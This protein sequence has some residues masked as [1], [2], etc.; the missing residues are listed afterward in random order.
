VL[1][2]LAIQYVLPLSALGFAYSQIGSTIRK[3]VKKNTTVD[4]Q[5]KQM[6]NKRNRKAMLLLLMLVLIYAVAWLPINL[7]NVLNVLDII[8][9]SQYRYIFCHLIGMCSACINPL[10][11]ALIN[12][13]FRTAFVSML[14]PFLRPCTKYVVVPG[15]QGAFGEGGSGLASNGREERYR[16]QARNPTHTTSSFNYNGESARVARGPAEP[17]TQLPLT[18]T[19]L[20]ARESN[21]TT[22][23]IDPPTDSGRDSRA[24]SERIELS[25]LPSPDGGNEQ[26]GKAAGNGHAV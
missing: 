16:S 7:Y 5:R 14:S 18:L 21:I 10:L 26:L 13:S 4:V 11:Y 22:R 23:I 15:G 1:T 25:E 20:E 6:L 3:R 8:E 12:D 17:F 19:I 24:E 9:F 2:V